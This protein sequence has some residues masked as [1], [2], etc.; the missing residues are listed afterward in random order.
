M[1]AW[2]G[3][4]DIYKMELNQA[5]Q[6]Q[7]MTL[8]AQLTSQL[9][10]EQNAFNLELAEMELEANNKIAMYKGIGGLFGTILTI[11]FGK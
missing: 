10:Q 7:N 2:Q 5:Y 8:Q 4:M 11:I 1:Q 9:N 6:T 3:K